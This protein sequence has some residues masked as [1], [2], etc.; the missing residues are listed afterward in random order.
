MNLLH[1]HRIA[2]ADPGQVQVDRVLVGEAAE[3][4]HRLYLAS[5]DHLRT[6]A[7]AR[8]VLH[9]GEFL[10]E[11]A[12]SRILKYT[13]WLSPTEPIALATVTNRLE[14]V[15]WVSPEFFAARHPAQAARS[16]I[17]YLG[18]ALVTPGRRQYRLL[19]RIVD[20]LAAPCVAEKGVLAYDMCAFNN[21]TVRFAARAEAI[22]KRLAPV[23]VDV[24]DTQ[25]YFEAKFL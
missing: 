5:F 15:T 16:S 3:S 13:V 10:E 21:R 20:E 18:I 1:K 25:T 17:Y 2:P 7:A 22:L 24:A 9:P 12:D 11:M 8:Q 6:E 4:L 23:Q 14:A 19:E